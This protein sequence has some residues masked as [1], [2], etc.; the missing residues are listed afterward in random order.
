MLFL[1]GSFRI[2]IQRA[3][4]H[5]GV[6]FLPYD[7]RGNKKDGIGLGFSQVRIG[8]LQATVYSD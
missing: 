8:E 6:I 1:S 5:V 3:S 7:R 4:E 2:P